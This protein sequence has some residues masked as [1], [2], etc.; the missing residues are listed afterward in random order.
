MKKS[1]NPL[2]QVTY[3]I[4][5]IIDDS[6]GIKDFLSKNI[7]KKVVVVQGLGF[8]GAVMSLVCANAEY[9]EYAVIGIDLPNEK[10]FWK[11]KSIN[12]G[13]FPL[14]AEDPKIDE[15]FNHAKKQGNFYATY[16]PIC[17]KYADVVIVDINLDVQKESS[18]NYELSDFDVDLTSFKEAITSVGK[19]AKEDALML[20]E[21][22]VPPGTCDQV[23]RPIIQEELK[24]RNLSFQDFAIGHSYE[25]VMPGPQY[26]DSIKFFPRVYSGINE[27]SAKRTKDFLKTIIDTNQCDLTQ[28]EHTNATEMAKVLENSYRATN[29]AFAVEWSRFAE[30]AGVDLYEIV[31]A[32]RVRKTHSNLMYPGIGVGGYCLTKD[33]LLASWSRK[34]I[35]GS[36]SGLNMS[37]DSVSINDRMPRYAYQRLRNVFGDLKDKNILLLGISYRGDVGDTRYS[38]V[39]PLYKLLRE[40]GSNIIIH[41]P[42][43]TF[44]EEQNCKVENDFDS[45]IKDNYDLIIVSTGHSFYS[46]DETFSKIMNL[47]PLQIY[48]TIGLFGKEQIKELVGK[49]NLSVLGRGDI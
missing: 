34:N 42:Y 37:T 1:I 7:G 10:S 19:Y 41:D 32:I 3:D 47:D 24:K 8:V 9:E 35:F 16:D 12:D 2:N 36:K 48:D 33:P 22:T 4:P 11:I 25:R 26:I 39:E 5:E 21:T 14:V 45:V 28:L 20:V 43:I 18:E 31:N 46:N 27:E 38:P 49:H 6:D 44:W 23:I 17:F 30:E 40:E 29:I 13:L 15:F